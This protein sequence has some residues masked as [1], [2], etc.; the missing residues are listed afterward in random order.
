M[1]AR[2]TK[3]RDIMDVLL[4]A[5]MSWHQYLS[6]MMSSDVNEIDG[7]SS[8]DLINASLFADV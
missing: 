8:N 1:T 6:V 4:C 3:D 2:T 7:G 5:K